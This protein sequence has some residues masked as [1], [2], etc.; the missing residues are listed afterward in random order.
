MVDFANWSTAKTYSIG[1]IVVYGGSLLRSTVDGNFNNNPSTST[2]WVAP[3]EDEIIDFSYA[4]SDNPPL[5]S[6]I[7]DMLIS[8]YVKYNYILNSLTST[9]FKKFD[10]DKAL[11]KTSML[12]M[13]RERALMFLLEHKPVEALYTLYQIKDAYAGISDPI[14]VRSHEVKYT[15]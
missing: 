9:S 1:D 10:N 3:T 4:V 14:K 8:R 12:Q 7:S 15:I 13:I 6:V 5:S 11:E 2:L